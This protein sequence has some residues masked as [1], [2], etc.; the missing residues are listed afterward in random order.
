MDDNDNFASFRCDLI[1]DD[2]LIIGDAGLRLLPTLLVEAAVL[3]RPGGFDLDLIRLIL[4]LAPWL[5]EGMREGECTPLT[6]L[7]E[8]VAVSKLVLAQSP[9]TIDGSN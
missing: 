2:G 6:G 9:P 1:F 4:P 7:M 3:L 5:N 8:S